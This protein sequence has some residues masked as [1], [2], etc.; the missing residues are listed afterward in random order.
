MVKRTSARSTSFT[1]NHLSKL[2][3][4]MLMNACCKSQLERAV[5]R[6]LS[7]HQQTLT[8]PSGEEVNSVQQAVVKG[9]TTDPVPRNVVQIAEAARWTSDQNEGQCAARLYTVAHWDSQ[10][11]KSRLVV[12]KSAFHHTHA[13]W[14]S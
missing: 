10:N 1:S 3:P 9:T 7:L 13:W 2:A 11:R 6:K 8:S 5:A 14:T 12:P 4:G